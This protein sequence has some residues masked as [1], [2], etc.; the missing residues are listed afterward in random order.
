MKKRMARLAAIGMIV[1]MTISLCAGCGKKEETQKS[2]DGEV[3]LRFASWENA[4]MLDSQQECVDNSMKARIK[5]RSHWKRMVMTLI[6]NLQ[7]AWV[8]VTHRM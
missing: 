1:T 3:H 2:K 8:P 4:E 6:R 5:L 7:Q